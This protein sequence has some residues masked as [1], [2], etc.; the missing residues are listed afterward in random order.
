MSCSRYGGLR[1]APEIGYGQSVGLAVLLCGRR[2]ESATPPGCAYPTSLLRCSAATTGAQQGGTGHR[3]Q[4]VAPTGGRS[5][6]D[7]KGGPRT[8]KKLDFAIRAPQLQGEQ[9]PVHCPQV[10]VRSE[11]KDIQP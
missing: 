2:P 5:L 4:Q 6:R 10:V 1:N 3:P 9:S 11:V 8:L 7:G